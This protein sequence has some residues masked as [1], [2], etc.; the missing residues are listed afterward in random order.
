M[1]AKKA[2]KKAVKKAPDPVSD[3]IELLLVE[4]TELFTVSPG[5]LIT[6]LDDDQYRRRKS[7]LLFVEGDAAKHSEQNVYKSDEG[8]QFK[9]G[10]RL[11]LEYS[12]IHKTQRAKLTLVD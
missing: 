6:G 8:L 9:V 2:V 7:R 10:E 12:A 3:G 5:M 1:T 4:I 11:M